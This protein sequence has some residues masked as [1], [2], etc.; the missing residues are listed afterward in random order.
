MAWLSGAGFVSALAVVGMLTGCDA[1]TDVEVLRLE[2]EPAAGLVAGLGETTRFLVVARGVGGVEVSADGA[3]WSSDRPSVA[4]VDSRGVVTG[5]GEGEAELTVRLQGLEASASV[6]VYVPPTITEYRPGISYL[7]RRGYV[8]YVPGELPVILSA[9]HGGD[10]A[11]DEMADRTSGV[12]VTDTNTREL[13]WAVRDAFVDLTGKA[14]HVIVSHLDRGK[15]DPNREI[16]EA[17]QGDPFA[18]QAWEEYHDF[19]EEAR[20]KVA[21]SGEGMYFDM[22]GHGHP[23]ARLEL[24]YL[25][26]ADRLNGDDE[27]L[28][29]LATV[30][31]TSIREIGSDSSLPF[32]QLLRGPTSLGGLLQ[33][34]GVPSVPSPDMPSPGSDPYFSGGYST[35]RHGSRAD[36]E[37]VSGIQLE[38]HYPGIRDNDANRRAYSVLLA[39][40]VR[41]FM[42]EHIGRFED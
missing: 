23:V 11:P 33:D 20:N 4:V 2:V 10:L 13:T 12:A 17:A 24:G 37:L 14:P 32:S 29:G 38:H 30:Q 41:D 22:H 36:T 15:L 16:V 6:E 35:E 42:L 1:T 28:N 7:G 3:E 5:I 18:E 8:E 39:E 34:R 40:A 19:I 21:I 25:L 31:L 26:S 27:S 9:P